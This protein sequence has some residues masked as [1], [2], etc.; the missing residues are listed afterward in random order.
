[1]WEILVIEDDDIDREALRRAFNKSDFEVSIQEAT[2][3]LEGLA[4]LRDNK[5]SCVLLDF[6][7]PDMTGIELL[8]IIKKEFNKIPCPILM[9]TGEGSEQ[10]AV[11]ALKL[12]AYDYIV[13]GSADSLNKIINSVEK[14]IERWNLLTNRKKVNAQI[15]RNIT[16]ERIFSELMRL[17]LEMTSTKA[18]LQQF[19]NNINKTIS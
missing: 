19:I 16:H 18:F 6:L 2:N 8:K 3:G 14:S 15:K 10:I 1:M 17:S 7:L 9:L 5:F 12:G 4:T 11:E 13:K